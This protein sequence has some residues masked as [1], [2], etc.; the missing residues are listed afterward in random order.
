MCSGDFEFEY[1]VKNSEGDES[2]LDP[3]KLQGGDTIVFSAK[4]Q[5]KVTDTC[6]TIGCTQQSTYGPYCPQCLR[7]SVSHGSFAIFDQTGKGKAPQ[8]L[9]GTGSPCLNISQILS[10]IPYIDP[11]PELERQGHRTQGCHKALRCTT[12]SETRLKSD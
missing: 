9:V 2:P 5:L 10:S 4:Q 8:T 1:F 11:D 7:V 3:A 6:V 12:Y